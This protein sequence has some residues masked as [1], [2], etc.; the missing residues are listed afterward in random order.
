MAS[1]PAAPSQVKSAL[2]V[3]AQKVTT[4]TDVGNS[5]A[6]AQHLLKD[7]TSFEEK[8]S[9]SVDVG[10]GTVGTPRPSVTTPPCDPKPAPA[11]PL[12]TPSPP[13]PTPSPPPT[14]PQPAPADPQPAPS[15]PPPTQ[16][17][18][19]LSAPRS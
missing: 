16:K 11:D 18:E 9:V 1:H 3:L 15:P 12:L 6:H 2:D 10:G 7:L 8:S 17:Q 13:P 14:H 19:V 5:L 4:F